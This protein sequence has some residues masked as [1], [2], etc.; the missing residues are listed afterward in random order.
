M[1]LSCPTLK[2]SDSSIT[3]VTFHLHS[4]SA[5]GNLTQMP[6]INSRM[7]RDEA[8]ALFDLIQ[9]IGDCQSVRLD[10]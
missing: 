4:L 10:E 2:R 6:D 5:T 8:K 7:P 9:P 3:K 1:G